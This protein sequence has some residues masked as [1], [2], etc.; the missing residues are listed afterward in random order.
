[1]N[2]TRF[3][4]TFFAALAVCAAC[5]LDAEVKMPSVF[6]DNMLVQRGKPAKFWGT[7]ERGGRNRVRRPKEIR[8]GGGGRQV[9]DNAFAA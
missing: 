7:A 6:S 4:K 3:P 2:M 5:L 8:K 1:M 9:E